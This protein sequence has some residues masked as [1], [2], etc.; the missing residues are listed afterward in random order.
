[1]NVNDRQLLKNQLEQQARQFATEQ[2]NTKLAVSVLTTCAALLRVA[3]KNMPKTFSQQEFNNVFAGYLGISNRVN[4]FYKN[5][6][7][8]FNAT[9]SDKLKQ[10]LK[11]LEEM[12]Q[13][14]KD[15][16]VKIACFHEERETTENEVKQLERELDVEREKKREIERKKSELHRKLEDIQNKITRLESESVDITSQINN[17]EP[18]IELL[19]NNVSVARDTYEEMLAYYSEL[20]RIQEGIREEGFV[21]VESFSNRLEEMN[22]SGKKIIDQY[23]SILKKLTSD[24]EALQAKIEYRRKGVLG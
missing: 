18:S 2:D 9:E 12:E 11:S 16:E 5:N 17:L 8:F 1:M 20:Q 24:I 15:L 4:G 23:D 22:A 14:K 19:I 6:T 13:A 10:I 7:D 21:N 3:E